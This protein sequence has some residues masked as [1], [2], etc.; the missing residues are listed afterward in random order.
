MILATD[1]P[2]L[3]IVGTMVVFFF[4]VMWFWCLI[5][6]LS[7]VFRR[8]DLGGWSKALWTLAMVVI[9]LIGVLAYLVV[10]G[11]DMAER[12][13]QDAADQRRVIDDHIRTVAH[14][15]NGATGP[16]PAATA[17]ATGPASEIAHAKDLLDSG[18]ID[19][20]EYSQLKRKLLAV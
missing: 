15:G 12:R 13:A 16:A 9:P 2:F 3:D 5:V 17:A 6:V 11:S 10:H 18:A 1:Y 8:K 20:E 14:G 7:D 19:A 4:W